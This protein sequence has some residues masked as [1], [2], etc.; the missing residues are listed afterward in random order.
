MPRLAT[1]IEDAFDSLLDKVVTPKNI[2]PV[3]RA[4]MR[5][6]FFA[7]AVVMTTCQ[8]GRRLA[9]ATDEIRRFLGVMGVGWDQ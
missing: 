6:I 2:D 3:M 7:G 4:E 5:K 1:P 9:A 8:R